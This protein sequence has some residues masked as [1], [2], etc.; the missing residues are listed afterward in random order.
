MRKKIFRFFFETFFEVP[1]KS[2]SAEK[3]ERGTIW[4][5]LNILWQNIKTLMGDP[6]EQFKNFG[7]NEKFEQSHSA[8]KGE[9]RILIV[10]KKALEW[11]FLSQFRSFGCVEN[12]VLS[13]YGKSA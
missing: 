5:F 9:S 7:K 1:G 4:E 11:F 6:L 3:C 12:E 8:E 10:S 2:H 13:T